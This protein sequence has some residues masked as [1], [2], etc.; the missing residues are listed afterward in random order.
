MGIFGALGALRGYYGRLRRCW[1]VGLWLVVGVPLMVILSAQVAAAADGNGANLIPVLSWIEIKDSQGIYIWQFFLSIDQGGVTKPDKAFWGMLI[2]LAWMFYLL[3]M[4]VS[5]WIIDWALGFGWLQVFA[6]PAKT[7]GD[8]LEVVVGDVDV[9]ITFLTITMVFAVVSM[10]RGRWALGV[11]EV[12]VSM[13]VAAMAT[14]ALAS[15][16]DLMTGNDGYVFAARDLGLGITSGL[17]NGGDTTKPPEKVRE[18]VMAAMVDSFVRVP[19]QIV[20]FG[21]VIDGTK[22]ED[23]YNEALAAGPYNDTDTVRDAMDV[24]DDGLGEIAKNPNVG[25][26]ITTAA[27]SPGAGLTMLLCVLV[28]GS[29]I[30]AGAQATWTALKSIVTLLAGMLP[31]GARGPMWM[32]I[33]DAITSLVI[34]VFSVVFLGGLMLMMQTVFASDADGSIMKKF[35]IIDTVMVAGIVVFLR[36]RKKI[37]RSAARLAGA[38][39]TRPKGGAPTKLPERT[40]ASAAGMYYK[41]QMAAGAVRTGRKLTGGGG[42]GPSPTPS[43]SP[44]GPESMLSWGDGTRPPKPTDPPPPPPPPPPGPPTSEPIAIGG[45]P[46]GG[47][48]PALGAGSSA[49][50]LRA[51]GSRKNTAGRAG[52]LVRVGASLAVATATGGASAAAQVGAKQAGKAVA[53]QAGRKVVQA[54]ARRAAVTSRLDQAQN[55]SGRGSKQQAGK[56]PAS[57]ARRTPG[58]AAAG[59]LGFERVVVDGQVMH[60]PRGQNSTPPAGGRPATDARPTRTQPANS[61]AAQSSTTRTG[62]KMGSPHHQDA[63]AS[64]PGPPAAPTRTTSPTTA[65]PAGTPTPKTPLQPEPGTAD[66]A[67]RLRERLKHRSNRP[68]PGPRRRGPTRG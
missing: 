53:K 46:G 41:S 2:Q 27:L 18:D 29:V 48:N 60:V 44:K 59:G 67:E 55:A 58:N 6:V 31:G 30:M 12:L 62:A 66:A 13:V 8:A 51:I 40:G 34:L 5:L 38:L 17:A 3:I 35:F 42:S 45:P 65:T 19:N 15:P 61:S 57:A 21:Q 68:G 22:C 1:R 52:T 16:V 33:A 37:K 9:A 36:Q 23:T 39:A 10:A 63:G 26:V 49:E 47:G 43:A 20:N 54:S 56:L 50:R 28:A 14:G 4:C 32:T 24:C 11:F 64:T 7:I 25:M